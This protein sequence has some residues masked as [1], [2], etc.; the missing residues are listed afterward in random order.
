MSF[1]ITRHSPV[2]ITNDTIHCSL[3]CNYQ[4]LQKVGYD[5]VVFNGNM[6]GHAWNTWCKNGTNGKRMSFSFTCM[7]HANIQINWLRN[8]GPL[9]MDYLFFDTHCRIVDL[10]LRVNLSTTRL[11]LHSCTSGV[12]FPSCSSLSLPLSL[13]LSLCNLLISCAASSFSAI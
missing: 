10:Y 2:W 7:P 11:H 8:N 5:I 1:L 4:N 12:V 13:S 6:L 9:N 3:P